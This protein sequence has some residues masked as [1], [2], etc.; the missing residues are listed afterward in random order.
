MNEDLGVCR[1][2]LRIFV[3]DYDE[4]PYK[5]LNYVG[6]EVNY[7]GRVTDDKD[8]RLIR[9][10]L[11]NFMNDKCMTTGHEY[12]KSGI[13]KVI[14]PG[15]KEDYIEYIKTFPLNPEPE[16]FGLHENAEITTNQNNTATLLLN[17]LSM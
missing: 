4:I 11:E 6:A 17:V 5:V 3:E 16:A 12:S 15:E 1:K 2:Q 14:E 10:I 8:S 9:T 7:G 13:Y